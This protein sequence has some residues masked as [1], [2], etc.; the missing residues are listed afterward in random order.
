ME[1]SFEEIKSINLNKLFRYE[2]N[3]Y[4]IL[5][6]ISKVTKV[7]FNI[8]EM[9][10]LGF[11]FKTPTLIC[12]DFR[13]G[14]VI[15]KKNLSNEAIN[16]CFELFAAESSAGTPIA[17]WKI[18]ENEHRDKCRLLFTYDECT[19]NWNFN[20]S[21]GNSQVIQKFIRSNPLCILRS[22]YSFMWK[23]TVRTLL[24]RKRY[25]KSLGKGFALRKNAGRMKFL[26]F[27]HDD[28]DKKPISLNQVDNKM[29]YLVYLMEKY[30]IKEY[31]IKVSHLRCNWIQ[32]LNGKVYWLNLKDYKISSNSIQSIKS[33]GLNMSTTLPTLNYVKKLKQAHE[34][35]RVSSVNISIIQNWKDF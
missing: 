11:G 10:I 24:V 25:S 2:L 15:V 23:N 20:L 30:Y 12:S 21:K 31:N 29:L 13:T 33:G 32:D 27:S 7:Y 8:P 19:F 3:F 5:Y 34:K 6:K 18:L 14:E 28:C 16:A 35:S 1:K 22:E 4:K 17:V 9:L 26:L